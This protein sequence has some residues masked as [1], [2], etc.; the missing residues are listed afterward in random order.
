MGGIRL[1]PSS[2]FHPANLQTFHPFPME[3]MSRSHV[4][5]YTKR[6]DAPP[7]SNGALWQIFREVMT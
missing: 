1:L 5:T 4:I 6:F 2:T 3:Q 7:A